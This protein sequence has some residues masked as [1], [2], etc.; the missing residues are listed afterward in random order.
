MLC[1]R[2]KEGHPTRHGAARHIAV[3]HSTARSTDW[4]SD[5]KGYCESVERLRNPPVAVSARMEL[6]ELPVPVAGGGGRPTSLLLSPATLLP[7][8]L[9]QLVGASVLPL[10][11]VPLARSAERNIGQ[12]PKGMSQAPTLLSVGI[13]T[14]AQDQIIQGSTRCT[15]ATC[16]AHA[17]LQVRQ[18]RL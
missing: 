11:A 15:C 10:P 16:A 3:H 2:N 6:E 8:P 18:V 1:S 14:G 12:V 5:A 9:L 7:P 13:P 4:H 17:Y